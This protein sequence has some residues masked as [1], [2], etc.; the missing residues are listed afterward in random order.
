MLH[1]RDS[2]FCASFEPI[3]RWGGVA[4]VKLPPQSPNLTAIAERFVRSV[5]S[6]CLSKVLLFGEDALRR[7]LSEYVQRYHTERSHQG[8]GSQI[9]FP[10][11][12]L[13]S[14][15]PIAC[16]QRLGGVLKFYCRKAA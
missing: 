15:G 14:Q 8:M 7:A 11:S 16:K 13:P 2:K 6:E 3:I 10:A 4:L 5:K 12:Q 1:D 9:L